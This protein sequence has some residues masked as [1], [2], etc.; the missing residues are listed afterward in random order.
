D[1]RTGEILVRDLHAEVP[2]ARLIQARAVAAALG[3]D[4]AG[5]FPLLPGMRL[6]STDP[7]ELILCGTWRPALSI[8]GAAGLP[9]P[10][11]G[12][13]V[14]RPLTALKLSL[15]LPPSV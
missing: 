9:L 10:E 14:L 12:G 2:E 1:E 13:N 15:R 11:D 8:T 6:T 7:L 4:L 3:S 5:K